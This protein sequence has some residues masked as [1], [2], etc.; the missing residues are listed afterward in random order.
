MVSLFAPDFS[1]LC[2]QIRTETHLAN[3]FAHVLIIVIHAQTQPLNY[4]STTCGL[5]FIS[6]FF[7]FFILG[8]QPRDKSAILGVN[9][10]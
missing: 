1:K 3:L 6:F 4:L 9:T 7:S 10:I 5:C 2:L 8:F